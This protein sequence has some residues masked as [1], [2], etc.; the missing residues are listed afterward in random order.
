MGN[1]RAQKWFYKLIQSANAFKNDP[2]SLIEKKNG[3][4]WS[5]QNNIK[6]FFL[7]ENLTPLKSGIDNCV[8][9]EID[10]NNVYYVQP[11][12][13]IVSLW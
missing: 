13:V 3:N 10:A 6:Y 4:V 11:G 1:L 9:R 7:S 5:Y 8:P 2:K 12:N